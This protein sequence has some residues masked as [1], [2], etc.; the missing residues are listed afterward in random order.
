MVRIGW[1]IADE[2]DCYKI[3]GLFRTRAIRETDTDST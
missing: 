2:L 3:F 1:D